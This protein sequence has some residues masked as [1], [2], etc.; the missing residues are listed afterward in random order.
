M[1]YGIGNDVLEI[2]RMRKL[3]SGRHA[4]AFIK[5]ILTPAEREIAAERGK[6][7]TEFVSGRFAAKEAVSKAFGCGIG[8]TM[9][10]TDIEVL[11]DETGR[12]VA[13][14]SSQAWERLQLPYDKQYDIHLS[15][16][17]QT[18]L[19]AAFAIVEQLEK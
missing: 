17:H 5:R 11:P 18:E 12:P 1:I 9:G 7:M 4:E 14:L 2:G 19:A 13:S 16:T 3:L 10:F 6:R 8:G 15:I